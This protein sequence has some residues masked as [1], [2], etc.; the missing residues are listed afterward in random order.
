M[1]HKK[2]IL[3]VT[4]TRAEYGLLRSTMDA[5]L[6]KHSVSLDVLVTGIHTLKLYGN[7]QEEVVADGYPVGIIVPILPED[8]MFESLAKELIGIGRYLEV[9]RPD[10][11]L[12]LGDRGEALAGA[13]AAAHTG[14]P[15]AHIHGGDRSGYVIDEP[16]R[17]S[18]TKFAHLHFVIC[19]SS[20]KR[21][22]QLGE[23]SW[24]VHMVGAPGMDEIVTLQTVSREEI[25]ER[26]SLDPSKRWILVV[27][28]PTINDPIPL[29]DQIVPLMKVL[30]DTYGED[31]KILVYPNS[32]KGADVFIREI[33]NNQGPRFHIHESLPRSLFLNVFAQS[34]AIVG[35]SSAGIIESGGLHIPSLTIGGRQSD[36]ERGQ[37]VV[38]SGYSESEI[39]KGLSQILS[40]SF[41]KHAKEVSSPY[42]EGGTGTRIADLIVKNLEDTRLLAKEFIDIPVTR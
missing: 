36:R 24:R 39:Q 15:I 25:A 30:Q 2:K 35:N 7:T 29:Q 6:K 8:S 26:L 17:H 28:H 42:G 22:L 10:C 19:P 21:V 37:N 3:V 18:I 5:L 40:E 27:H 9:N 4:G 41:R 32:D 14:I 33:K 16:I 23:E 12:V 20:E 38:H 11:I 31:E 13:L 34:V 1:M